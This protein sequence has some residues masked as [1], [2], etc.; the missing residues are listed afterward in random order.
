MNIKIKVIHRFKKNH[1]KRALFDQKTRK[2]EEILMFIWYNLIARK[3][4]TKQNI[5]ESPH[6]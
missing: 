3:K 6:E 1:E 4:H 2:K 5:K